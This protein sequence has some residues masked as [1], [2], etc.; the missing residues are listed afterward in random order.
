MFM[1]NK[2]L[3]GLWRFMIPIPGKVWQGQVSK[4]A[5]KIEAGLA[6]MSAEHHAVRNFVVRELPRV[7]EPLSPEF[8]GQ[9]LNLS[10]ARVTT[11]LEE[12]ETHLTFLFRNEQGAVAWA[13]PVTVDSTPH[14]AAFSTGEEI[15]LA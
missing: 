14:R 8:I 10:V 15:C 7:G 5:R 2:Q 3:M 13:Y 4:S 6:F 1:S 12:L 9:S 11:I